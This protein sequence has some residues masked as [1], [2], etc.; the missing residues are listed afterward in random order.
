V[1]GP[2]LLTP[3]LPADPTHL[4]PLRLDRWYADPLPL[5]RRPPQDLAGVLRAA[6]PVMAA[7]TDV[8]AALAM[9]RDVDPPL[10]VLARRY[11]GMWQRIPGLESALGH[12]GRVR[13]G[14]PR[15]DNDLYGAF[16]PEDRLRTLTGLDA[17]RLL[18]DGIRTGG[19]GLHT[20][21]HRLSIIADW[22][23]GR[24]PDWAAVQAAGELGPAWDPM[25]KS[26]VLMARQ[27]DLDVFAADYIP[28]LVP[29]KIEGRVYRAPTGAQ[30]TNTWLDWALWGPE[31]ARADPAY[32]AYSAQLRP[33]CS[34]LARSL[35]QRIVTTCGN[36]SLI[37]AL[38]TRF[39]PGVHPAARYAVLDGLEA[40]LR[41]MRDFR[42][43]HQ[44]F[45]LQTLMM[46]EPDRGSGMIEDPP[47]AGLLDHTRAARARVG[48]LRGS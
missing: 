5:T 26:A 10:C 35:G 37:S 20:V 12:L 40:L 23:V 19:I 2:L 42:A 8:P 30:F 34:P 22:V 4:D 25:V 11:P 9:L 21:M 27:M 14:L 45:A 1:T 18:I 33:E 48:A 31:V 24:R 41:R 38:E 44:R 13:Q 28:W 17:E 15:S 29:L 39:P 43:V 3:H 36:Q 6:V 46:R 16:N 7:T 32:R 47:F